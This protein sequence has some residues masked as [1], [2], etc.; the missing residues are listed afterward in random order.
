V[1]VDFLETRKLYLQQVA[2]ININ[3]VSGQ[4][5]SPVSLKASISTDVMEFMKEFIY[6][7][8][9]AISDERLKD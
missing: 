4:E 2:D 7:D 6:T 8:Q 1:I 3:A 9:G 5:K